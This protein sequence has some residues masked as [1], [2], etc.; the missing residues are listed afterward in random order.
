MNSLLAQA[1]PPITN[2]WELI[3][4]IIMLTVPGFL[5]LL[6]AQWKAWWDNRRLMA[7]AALKTAQ[8]AA[9]VKVITVNVDGRITELLEAVRKA[10]H[11]EG[12][13]EGTSSER[14]VAVSL[15]RDQT[16]AAVTALALTTEATRVEVERH[17]TDKPVPMTVVGPVTVRPEGEGAGHP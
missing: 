14:A 9:D 10:S 11:A 12:V 16:A 7:E 5:A 17:E 4:Y 13:L 8:L 6:G 2:Q 15:Q 3:A 1:L